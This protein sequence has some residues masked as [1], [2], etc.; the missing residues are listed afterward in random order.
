MKAVRF[1][2]YGDPRVLRYEDVEQPDAKLTAGQRVLING[3]GGGVGGYA[4]QLA[5]G[6]GAYVIA[7]AGP[8]SSERARSAGADAVVDHATTSVAAAVTEPVDVVLNLAPSIG[9]T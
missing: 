6:A 1:H 2:E 3:A 9:R 5:K 4:V 7:T 8:R